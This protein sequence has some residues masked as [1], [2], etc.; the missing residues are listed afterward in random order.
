MHPKV[1]TVANLKGGVGKSNIAVNLAGA[2]ASKHVRVVLIDADAQGTAM[3]WAAAGKLPFQVDS[4]PLESARDTKRWIDRA[5]SIEAGCLIVD[6]P[7]HAGDASGAAIGISD[8]VLIPVFSS[9]A[10]LRAT[11]QALDMV[12]SAR[13]IRKDGGPPCLMVPSRID[14]RTSSGQEIESVLK[15]FGEP[16]GPA[17]HQRAA[18]IDSLTEGEW[19]GDFAPASAAHDDITAL[20]HNVKRRLRL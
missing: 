6:C 13:A 15:E 11:V 20:A 1:V 3:S 19:I 7:P 9:G 8:L 16:I 17:V 12:R 2:L 14:R 10:D 5:L 4:M 18:F